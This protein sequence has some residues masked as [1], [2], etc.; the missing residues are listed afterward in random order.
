LD[1]E[2]RTAK[3]NYWKGFE[4]TDYFQLPP[5]QHEPRLSPSQFGLNQSSQPA[6]SPSV[7]TAWPQWTASFSA[8]LNSTSSYQPTQLVPG[9]LHSLATSNSLGFI[10]DLVTATASSWNPLAVSAP[11]HPTSSLPLRPYGCPVTD[12]SDLHTEALTG[13]VDSAQLVAA[14]LPLD[15]Y[16]AS[17]NFSTGISNDH[18]TATTDQSWHRQSDIDW[19]SFLSEDALSLTT[20]NSD[21]GDFELV[22]SHQSASESEQLQPDSPLFHQF[23]INGSREISKVF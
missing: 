15:P 13:P 21:V 7:E 11:L 12:P 1:V 17:G 10:S 4:P 3:P 16:S 2:K 14:L 19:P 18:L 8:S 9:A 23:S 22:S 6:Y 5:T 20:T